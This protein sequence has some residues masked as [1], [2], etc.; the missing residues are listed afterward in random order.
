MV[1]FPLFSWYWIGGITFTVLAL[2]GL[3]VWYNYFWNPQQHSKN[4]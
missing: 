4:F 2:I 3:G 1:D